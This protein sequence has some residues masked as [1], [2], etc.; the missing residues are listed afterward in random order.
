ML[1]I[2]FFV[3]LVIPVEYSCLKTK[4]SKYSE[5][6]LRPVQQK[7]EET[8]RFLTTRYGKRGG[9]SEEELRPGQQKRE[10]TGRFLTTRYGKRS[11]RYLFN[12]PDTREQHL[13]WTR[14]DN[15]DN[16]W[17]EGGYWL[18]KNVAPNDK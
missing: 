4:N 7:R 8:G 15:V 13:D 9:Y 3:V 14:K 16:L 2:F 18:R 10:D 17:S 6:E 12:A 1:W 11:G 5:E